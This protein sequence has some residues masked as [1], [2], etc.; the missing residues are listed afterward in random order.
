MNLKLFDLFN[1]LAGELAY[2]EDLYQEIAKVLQQ[3]FYGFAAFKLKRELKELFNLLK[4]IPDYDI[5]Y[6]LINDFLQIKNQ[7][8]KEFNFKYIASLDI[9]NNALKNIIINEIKIVLNKEKDFVSAI[10][11][12]N[13][14]L[15]YKNIQTS[16]YSEIIFAINDLINNLK[17]NKQIA[18]NSIA[19][20]YKLYN[21]YLIKSSKLDLPNDT[22][23]G[24]VF[25]Y[26]GTKITLMLLNEESENAGLFSAHRNTITIYFKENNINNCYDLSD[27]EIMIKEKLITLKHEL[28]H[29]VQFNKSQEFNIW[30]G[31]P[32]KKT[33]KEL[34]QIN[35]NQNQTHQLRDIE[36]YP[37][38]SDCIFEYLQQIKLLPKIL[39]KFCFLY[40][41]NKINSKQFYIL[42][43][44]KLDKNIIFKNTNIIFKNL[45]EYFKICR[46][47]FQILFENDQDKYKKA[48][49][50]F[51]KSVESYAN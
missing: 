7:E 19:Q 2:P 47:N 41:I 32:N 48:I 8:N 16:D 1:K 43:K 9:V 11:Y 45:V 30:Y 25:D 39:W 40:A 35:V 23:F 26:K 46:T 29:F 20:T 21:Y 18:L 27:Y 22:G 3:A 14:K 4:N 36:F 6:K 15:H 38:L 28:R 5:L 49:K 13:N 42:I 51:Y 44:N 34:Q 12:L 31:L 37:N 50:I 33:L 24:K 10:I 17:K